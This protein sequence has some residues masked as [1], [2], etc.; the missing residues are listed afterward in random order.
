ML[1]SGAKI[2]SWRR[3]IGDDMNEDASNQRGV[4]GPDSFIPPW[5]WWLWAAVLVVSFVG[6]MLWTAT[7]SSRALLIAPRWSD[8]GAQPGGVSAGEVV[9]L[10]AR[11]A[12]GRACDKRCQ[13]LL[14]GYYKTSAEA[15]YPIISVH[16]SHSSRR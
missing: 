2:G 8:Q 10:Q 12:S 7:L 5:A 3:P 14:A 11:P 13:A 16:P 4:M 9:A 6:S 15:V 1:P